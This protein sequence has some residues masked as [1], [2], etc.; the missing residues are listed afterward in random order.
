[1]NLKPFMHI[2]FKIKKRNGTPKEFI[3]FITHGEKR[4]NKKFVLSGILYSNL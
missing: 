4:K 1:M 2:K 3:I